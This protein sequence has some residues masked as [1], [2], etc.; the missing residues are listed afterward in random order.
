MAV[1]DSLEACYWQDFGKAATLTKADASATILTSGIFENA[2]QGENY[3]RF[4]RDQGRTAAAPYFRPQVTCPT[5]DAAPYGEGDTL[6]FESV[7]YTILDDLA[8]GTQT[9]FT[10]EEFEDQQPG[11]LKFYKEALTF[12]G[13]ELTFYGD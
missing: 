11:V 2:S 7:E 12:Y 8:D 5:K 13:E 3:D 9:T 1:D 6:E 10:L 4:G